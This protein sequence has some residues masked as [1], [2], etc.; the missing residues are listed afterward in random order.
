MDHQNHRAYI[1]QSHHI[2]YIGMSWV[3]HEQV[4]MQLCSNFYHEWDDLGDGL[5]TWKQ[6]RSD[7]QLQKSAYYQ[8]HENI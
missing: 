1:Q 3:A 5:E 4:E 7:E 2:D 6:E 8:V